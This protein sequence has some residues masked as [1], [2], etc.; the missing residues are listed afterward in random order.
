MA[1]SHTGARLECHF[2]MAQSHT[3]ARLESRAPPLKFR[4]K[5]STAGVRNTLPTTGI[6]FIDSAAIGKN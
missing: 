4:K 1:P 2:Y 5:F 3:G 6:S